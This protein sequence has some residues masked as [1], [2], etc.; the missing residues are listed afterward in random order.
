MQNALVEFGMDQGAHHRAVIPFWALLPLQ[1]DVRL[2]SQKPSSSTKVPD[3]LE[4]VSFV[5]AVASCKGGVGKSTVAVNLAFTLKQ[6]GAEVGLLD[7]DLYGPSLP[8]LLPLKDTTVYFEDEGTRKNASAPGNHRIF[9][10]TS[11]KRLAASDSTRKGGQLI[12]FE[13]RDGEAA[14]RFASLRMSDTATGGSLEDQPAHT[15]PKLKPLVHAGVKLM[16]YGF[17][18]NAGSQGFSALR[19][20]FAS[21]VIEQLLTGTSWGELDYLVIDLPPGTGDIHITLSQAVKIDACVVV[22]TLQALSV[23]DAERGIKMF[24]EIGIPTVC[25]VQ[26]MSYFEC[27]ACQHRQV[28]FPETESVEVLALLADAPHVIKLPV[29]P[30][31][32]LGSAALRVARSV[33]DR[34]DEHAG[35]VTDA[36]FPFVE[37]CKET[38]SDKV[39]QLFRELGSH[40]V[41]ELSC[42][43]FGTS[44]PSVTLVDETHIEIALPRRRSRH[45]VDRA[46]SSST[47]LQSDPF[48]VLSLP[49]QRIR[50]A[51]TCK[52][53]TIH[54]GERDFAQSKSSSTS[55]MEV[56]GAAGHRL[57]F[58]WKDGHRTSLRVQ[59]LER[60]AAEEETAAA[61]DGANSCLAAAPELEW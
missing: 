52:E 5:V 10:K 27:C 58:T 32:S 51:C 35:G 40:V 36:V 48:D 26:N 20:P 47:T 41:R 43:R 18:R 7:A 45:T 12:A 6:L 17:I 1:V 39:W 29:D 34:D 37:Q 23:A 13:K 16:S 4:K 55:L 21:S 9:P 3:G 46:A 44:P 38:E 54:T 61:G 22:T 8:V 28:L 42:L 31:L 30:R 11:Q 25:V 50:D 14:E 33:K 59:T 53:C 49:L 57:V 56:N 24:N 19:G 60:M 15:P 2:S